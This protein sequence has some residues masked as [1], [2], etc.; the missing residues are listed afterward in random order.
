LINR[1]R[2]G[3]EINAIGY[4]PVAAQSYGIDYR[5]TIMLSFFIG[6]TCGIGRGPEDSEHP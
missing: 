3:Y 1:T 6:G 5:K 2:L 4:N